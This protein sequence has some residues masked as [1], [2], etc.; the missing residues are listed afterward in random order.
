MAGALI[1]QLTR[2]QYQWPMAVLPLDR[3]WAEYFKTLRTSAGRSLIAS[4]LGY[5]FAR[6]E[7]SDYQGDVNEIN[8]SKSE[9]QGRPMGEAYMRNQEFTPIGD[10][11]CPRHRVTQYGVFDRHDTLR[12]YTVIHRSG[13]LALVSQILGHGDHERDGIMHLLM[14]ETYREEQPWGGHLVYNRMDSGTPGLQQ[15]KRWLRFEA[16]EITWQP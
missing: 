6:F 14:T 2:G 4:G 16:T 3:S 10:A 7:R 15:F 13:E 5:Q 11:K 8:Q 1:A 12:A 9:R